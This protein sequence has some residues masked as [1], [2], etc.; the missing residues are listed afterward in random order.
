MLKIM[1]VLVS[2]SRTANFASVRCVP[3]VMASVMPQLEASTA[4]VR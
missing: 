1:T 3:L 4:C 2:P